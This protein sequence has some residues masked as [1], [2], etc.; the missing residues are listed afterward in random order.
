LPGRLALV[1]L[2]VLACV[3]HAPARLR[4]APGSFVVQAGTRLL[5]AA[6]G[7]YDVVH[8]TTDGERMRVALDATCPPI[9]ARAR[10]RRLTARWPR[11][12]CAVPESVTLKMVLDDGCE[13]ARGRVRRSGSRAVALLAARCAAD[14]VV[15]AGTGEEYAAADACGP[16]RRCVDCRCVPVVGFVRDVQPI[17]QNCLTAACHEGADAAGSFELVPERAYEE[18]LAR[19]ARAG[20]CGGQPLVVPG[21]PDASVLWKRVGG[22]TCGASM[23]LGSPLL[24]AADVD[25]IRAWIAQGAPAN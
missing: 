7:D 6:S 23:P 18:L 17:F 12:R 1:C 8:V 15:S 14:D 19:R 9:R 10:G 2:A 11:G 21:D 13:V 4:C 3:R 5:P 25:A 22:T 24:P 16:D 20:A